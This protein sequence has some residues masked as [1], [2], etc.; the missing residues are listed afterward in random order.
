MVVKVLAIC[1]L[2][3]G[4]DGLIKGK[5]FSFNHKTQI[6]ICPQRESQISLTRSNIPP[7]MFE[8]YDAP[9]V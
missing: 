8:T 1:D 4:R 7:E 9:P 2:S 6:R 5:T 3:P